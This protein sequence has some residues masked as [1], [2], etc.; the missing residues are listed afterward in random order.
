MK[1][2]DSQYKETDKPV[3]KKDF[4]SFLE[5]QDLKKSEQEQI[6]WNERKKD[7]LRR[8]DEFYQIV[9]EFMKEYLNQ[10]KVNI[11]FSPLILNEEYIGS[12]ETK[13]L[14]LMTGNQEVVFSP[15]GTRMIGSGGRIDMEGK[16]GKVRFVLVDKDKESS[17]ISVRVSIDG[18]SPK[19]K[20]AEKKKITWVWKIA[21]PPPSVSLISLNEERFFDALM[22]V[23]NG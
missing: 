11:H 10:E 17:G 18:D 12:Y 7:W 5:K 16:A 23:I 21:T 20:N 15:V 13:R 2:T 14:H 1:K 22:E 8:I 19:E 4:E 3:S 6:D 9:Q